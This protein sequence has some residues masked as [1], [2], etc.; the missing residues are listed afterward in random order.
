MTTFFALAADGGFSD[1]T[2]AGHDQVRLPTV[3]KVPSLGVR[4][5]E[6]LQGAQT[7]D[8]RGKGR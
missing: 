2:R 7:A 4:P 3:R 6:T 1:P 5:G 8:R